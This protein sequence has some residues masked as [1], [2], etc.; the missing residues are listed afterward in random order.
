MAD[1]DHPADPAAAPDSDR[2]R[3]FV[4]TKPGS[5]IAS[6]VVPVGPNLFAT[7]AGF[8]VLLVAPW[9]C[10][11]ILEFMWEDALNEDQIANL[12]ILASFEDSIVIAVIGALLFLVI[13]IILQAWQHH[14]PFRSRWAIVLAFPIICILIVPEAL[15]RGGTLLSGT[16]VASAIAVAFSL[17]WA[18]VVIMSE[19]MS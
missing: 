9:I 15:M 12:L 1:Q 11:N 8:L 16:V 13:G 18:I 3:D 19:A 17:H 14:R 4:L 10:L 5:V 6:D 2:D 7:M